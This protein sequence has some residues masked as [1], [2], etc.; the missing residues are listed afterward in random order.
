M[1]TKLIQDYN[2]TYQQIKKDSEISITI[3]KR[4]QR[5]IVV[6]YIKRY[7][8]SDKNIKTI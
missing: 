8:I 6:N 1:L 2:I 5:K 3:I 4:K 7:N